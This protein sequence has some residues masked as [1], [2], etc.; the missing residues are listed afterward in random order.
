MKPQ[1]VFLCPRPSPLSDLDKENDHRYYSY[2]NKKV[3][4]TLEREKMMYSKNIHRAEKAFT[5]IELL[6]VVAIIGIL[7]AIAI[8]NF[9]E[10]QVRAKVSRVKADLRSIALA[11]EVYMTDHNAYPPYGRIAPDGSVEYPASVNNMFDTMSF[12]GDCMTT[13]VAYL[14]SF[15]KDP[16]ATHLQGPQLLRNYEYLNLDQH[17]AN[18]GS[19]APPFAAFLIPA[20]GHWRMVGAGPDGDRGLDVKQNRIYD[21]TNGTVSD[22]DI[23]RC[24]RYPESEWNSLAP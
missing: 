5:L 3:M 16:F 8:P 4:N 23:V 6:I 2:K 24:Q 22:G 21:P 14:G 13:P 11:L 12:A 10:A 17:V 20:W 18:F 15:P 19:S 1:T 7:A 9:L